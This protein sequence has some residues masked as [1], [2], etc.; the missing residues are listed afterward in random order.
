MALRL[1]DT[2]G[3]LPTPRPLPKF[4]AG[5]LRPSCRSFIHSFGSYKS[6]CHQY[7]W[8]KSKMT[9]NSKKTLEYLKLLSN[10]CHHRGTNENPWRE[11]PHFMSIGPQSSRHVLFVIE[12][13]DAGVDRHRFRNHG[14]QSSRHVLL[15]IEDSDAGMDRHRSRNHDFFFLSFFDADHFQSLY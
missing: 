1:P 13:S 12:D 5:S 3:Y 15:V 4:I 7:W 2:L 9:P 8:N 6:S 10:H 11:R 14:P